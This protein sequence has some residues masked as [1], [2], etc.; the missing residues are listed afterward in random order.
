M[1]LTLIELSE[2]E[3]N[4]TKRIDKKITENKSLLPPIIYLEGGHYDPRYEISDFS[5]KSLEN[6][7]EYVWEL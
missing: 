7:L 4:I 5:I 3:K 6:V 2:L 1:R